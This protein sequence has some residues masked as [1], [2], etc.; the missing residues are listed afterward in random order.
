MEKVY[1]T[2]NIVLKCLKLFIFAVL[3]GTAG[4]M[5]YTG[6]T[7]EGNDLLLTAGLLVCLNK[8]DHIENN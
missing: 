5:Y 1:K 7:S 2:T 6:R 4:V 8:L 3:I